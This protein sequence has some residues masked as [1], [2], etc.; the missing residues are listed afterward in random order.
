[1]ELYAATFDGVSVLTAFEA[2]TK[3]EGKAALLRVKNTCGSRSKDSDYH[4]HLTWHREKDPPRITLTVEFAK[5]NQPPRPN[6]Q[7]PF[8]EDFFVWLGRFV[9]EKQIRV[10]VYADFEFP[11]QAGRRVRFPLPMKAPV[12]PDAVEAEIDGISFTLFPT[13]QGV[14]KVWITQKE[15]KLTVHLHGNRVV[16]FGAFDPREDVQELSGVMDSMFKPRRQEMEVKTQ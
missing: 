6:E 7:E 2:C 4:L 10:E 13:P 1:M 16:T 15:E 3:A 8:A 14:E 5:G 11:R 9:K 12:G